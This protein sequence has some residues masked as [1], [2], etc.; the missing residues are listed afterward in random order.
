M[1]KNMRRFF[2]DDAV[3]LAYV[4]WSMLVVLLEYGP[5]NLVARLVM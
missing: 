3:G 5:G 1:A 2:K 4:S